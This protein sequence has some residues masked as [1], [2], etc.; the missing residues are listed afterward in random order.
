MNRTGS[1]LYILGWWTGSAFSGRKFRAGEM[2]NVAATIGILLLMALGPVTA[3]SPSMSGLDKVLTL[4]E[5]LDLALKNNR[6]I[7]ISG[8]I[9]E[10]A[11]ER[12]SQARVNLLPQFDI[13]AAGGVMLDT[14]KTH[15]PAGVL[16]SVNGSP[17]PSKDINLTS[18]HHFTSV[19]N[20]TI[21]QPR[22]QIPPLAT[23]LRLASVGTDIAREAER[24]Q[25]ITTTSS[26]RQLYFAI[27]QTQEG[28]KAANASL[29]SLHEL[30]RSVADNVVQQAALRADLLDVQG[31]VAAQEAGISGLL[32]T[33][34]KGKE[35]MNVLLGRGIKTP[36][37][38]ASGAQEAPFATPKKHLPTTTL[39]LPPH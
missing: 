10:Q 6:P 39:P 15:F 35:K 32:D 24:Q 2:V 29:K 5:A 1:T 36:F 31:R 14:V 17:V 7:A 20:I 22:P 33:L 30:E 16:G 25:R 19:Y 38:I 9:V 26:V 28:I 8:L 4:Q 12:V 37:Q 11:K 3:Q 18:N 23:A 21:A 34:Q 13:K 27:Q